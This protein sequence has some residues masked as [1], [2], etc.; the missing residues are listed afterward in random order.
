[1]NSSYWQQTITLR[2][3]QFPRFIGA[4]LDGITDSPFR[5]L[6]RRF[7]TDA[8]LYTEM[9]H[10]GSIAADSDGKRTVRFAQCER[11]LTYQIAANDIQYIDAAIA[12]ILAAGV[13]IVDLNVDALR[14]ML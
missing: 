11:P 1:M 4:P 9:R 3:Y 6:V 2:S 10:V 7:S 12:R 14:A 5:Q 8:L 13:D